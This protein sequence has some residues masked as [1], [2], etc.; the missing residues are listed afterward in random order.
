VRI[1]SV[2]FTGELDD[3]SPLEVLTG[4][5]TVT[6]VSAGSP[7]EIAVSSAQVTTAAKTI[8]GTSVIAGRAVTFVANPGSTAVTGTLYKFNIQVDTTASQTLVAQVKVV[9][10]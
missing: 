8:N 1:V 6:L 2:D 10:N 4:T 3:G 7:N 9:I 5:P